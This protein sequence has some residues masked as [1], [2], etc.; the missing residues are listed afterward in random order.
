MAVAHAGEQKW[1]LREIWAGEPKRKGGLRET[2]RENKSGGCVRLRVCVRLGEASLTLLQ[3]NLG[4]HTVYDCSAISTELSNELP[5]RTPLVRRAHH[6]CARMS[7]ARRRGRSSRSR[8][9]GRRTTF[10]WRSRLGAR[11]PSEQPLARHGSSRHARRDA[12]AHSKSTRHALDP[13]L[14]QSHPVGHRGKW[15][16]RTRLPK[17]LPRGTR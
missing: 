6:C 4:A 10:H 9:S 13:A 17:V 3:Y 16:K 5:C 15:S 2:G 12:L 11:A 8:A 1:G 7:R 14:A